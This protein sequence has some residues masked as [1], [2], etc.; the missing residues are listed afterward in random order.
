LIAIKHDGLNSNS[1]SGSYQ[2]WVKYT[3]AS[4]VPA[5]GALDPSPRPRGF[6]AGSG[7][8]EGLSRSRAK[9]SSTFSL[10]SENPQRSRV[11]R[12]ASMYMSLEHRSCNFPMN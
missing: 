10:L 3:K 11:T 2:Q 4:T 12:W 7:G 9:S 1:S 5:M 8:G 6:G